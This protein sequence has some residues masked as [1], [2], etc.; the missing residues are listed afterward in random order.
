MAAID[1]FN[2]RE[3]KE[4]A[5]LLTEQNNTGAAEKEMESTEKEAEFY[6]LF[7]DLHYAEE[8]YHFK[9]KSLVDAQ[10]EGE[11]IKAQVNASCRI[12]KAVWVSKK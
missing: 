11:K 3:S 12:A 7:V 5:G 8:S 1:K 4:I 9:Y 10:I 6:I 2:R